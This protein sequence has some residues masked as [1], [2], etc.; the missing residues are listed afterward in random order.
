LGDERVERNRRR[1]GGGE[2][3]VGHWVLEKKKTTSIALGGKR[4]PPGEGGGGGALRPGSEKTGG[5]MVNSGFSIKGELTE[6][7]GKEET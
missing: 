2:R 3:G 6:R 7:T 1:Q 5:A 4:L